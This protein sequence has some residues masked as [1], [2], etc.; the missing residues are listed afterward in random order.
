[1]METASLSH[2]TWIVPLALLAFYIGSPRFLGTQATTRLSRLLRT[3][4]DKRQ[5]TVLDQLDLSVG[6]RVVHFDH[7]VLGAAGIFVIDALQ[8]PGKIK[9]TKVQALWKRERLGRTDRID[10]PV[11]ENFLRVQALQQ[12]LGLDISRFYPL[13]AISGHRKIETDAND[14]LVDLRSVV[15]K[16]RGQVR[17]LLSGDELDT[18]LQRIQ[19][20]RVHAPLLGRNS[21]WKVL[22]LALVVLL[23]GGSYAAYEKELGFLYQS[24][25][26]SY[27]QIKSPENFNPTGQLKTENEK[28]EDSLV[29]S[30]SIDTGRCACYEPSGKKASIEANK[31]K[32]L[33][34]RGSI[35]NQ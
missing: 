10:N 14:V 12:S 8:L 19:Q 4:L 17:R 32:A 9:G 24:A 31:C 16:I 6:G 28:W 29:C 23:L 35:L 30:Y 11:H 3:S 34:E 18:A 26:L 33:A 20:L 21:R 1:M 7:L 27:Q 15:G 5:F 22:R 13:V 2:L 25:L